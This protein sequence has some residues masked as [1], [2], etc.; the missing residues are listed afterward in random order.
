MT[1]IESKK[2]SVS[3]PASEV[4]KFLTDLNNIEKLLPIDK[5]SEWKSDGQTCSF[6]VQKAYQIGFS[7][8][9]SE[10][11]QSIQYKSTEG[12][13]FPFDLNVALHENDGQTEA[14]LLCNA[15]INKFLEM[16]VKSPL[17]NLF[18]YMADKLTT[19]FVVA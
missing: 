7:L 16:L 18:D 3:A 14:Q 10:P 6:K 8:A 19:Q 5:I 2:V 9:E 1:K 17:K 15:E 12:T 11:H 13:P 4:F